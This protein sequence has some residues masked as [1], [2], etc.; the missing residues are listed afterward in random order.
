MTESVVIV[1]GSHAAAQL[2]AS[3][4]QKG[5]E[6][7][8]VLVS[9][10]EHLPYHRPPLS[11]AMMSGEQG[12]EDILIRP[13]GSYDALDVELRL[14]ERVESL[15]PVAMTVALRSGGELP[16]GKLVLTTG[17][18]VRRLPVPGAELPGVFYLRDQND[19]LAIREAAAKGGRAVVVGGGYIGLETAASLRKL[20][21]GVVVIEAMERVL[22][23]VTA[24]QMSDLYR[25]VHTEEGVEIVEGAQVSAIREGYDELIVE[26][27]AREFA[28][29][30]VVVGIGVIPNAELA[31]EAGLA[32]GDP[33]RGESG[34]RVDAHCRTSDPD[35]YA[36]G[37][38]A[39]HYSPV[40][41]RHLR[42]ESVPNAT[43]MAKTV[44]EHICDP[45][46][47]K[48]YAALP[49]FWSDQFD[50]KLQI[51]GLNAGHDEVVL[52][53]DAEDAR[54]LAAFYFKGNRLLAVDAVNDPRSFM[55]GKMAIA[56]GGR[57]DKA[58]VADG[59]ADLKS[60]LVQ[61]V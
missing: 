24:P 30:F 57:V 61:D 21:L 46:S 33:A 32:V 2:C 15:D 16:Y 6:G 41:D 36:A 19:A 17:A 14:G 18:R 12:V 39:W 52:R 37:D 44:A 60:A 9:D 47:A 48:A 11:K 59:S 28:A 31:E 43:D 4:R 1:G 20:G 58:V 56:R 25:R 22:Q 45:E 42:V 40:Y 55:F 27:G 54:K 35:I 26:T 5:W 53:E 34:I 50:L 51:A 7:G 38:V 13:R 10:E 29:D 49:W 23:R 8:I 3:L